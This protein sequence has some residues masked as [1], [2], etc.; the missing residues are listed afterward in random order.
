MFKN[1]RILAISIIFVVFLGL[2]FSPFISLLLPVKL[3]NH[4]YHR[5]LYHVIADGVTAGCASDRE[6]AV[7]IFGYVVDRTFLQGTPYKCKPAES[8]I[9][10]EAYCDF[11]ARILNALLGSAGI[12]SRYAALFDKNGVSPHT[13]NEVLLDGKWR[14]FDSSI[15]IVFRDNKGNYF[16][17]E[18]LSANPDLIF[19]QKK[20]MALKDYAPGVYRTTFDWFTRMFPIPSPPFRSIPVNSQLHIFDHITDAYYK[21][22]K[23]PFFDLYQ[24]LYLS[25]KEPRDKTG[26][27]LFFK[28]RNYHL[29]YRYAKALKYYDELLAEYPEGRY[30]QDAVF[31]LGMLYFDMKDFIESEKFFKLIIEKYP[32]KWRNASYYYLGL[33]YSATGNNKAAL[34]AYSNADAFRLPS[35]VL[36]KL[37]KNGFT[38]TL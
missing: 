22:F 28:A 38:Y 18:D 6:K 26:L 4:T 30:A 25:L 8:L 20:L 36:E 11:Q 27:P 17:L 19:Q 9:F 32:A 15:N 5:L 14:V 12:T 7:K 21:V 1:A 16:S 24:D 13:T 23:K 29:T 31:Y 33:I 10:G 34:S 2:L 37:N 3:T 35:D